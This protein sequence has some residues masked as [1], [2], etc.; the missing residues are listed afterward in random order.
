[1]QLN[2]KGEII[3]TKDC[4]TSVPGLF[5]AGDLTDITYKQIVISAGEGVK[6]ALQAYKFIQQGAGSVG[7]DWGKK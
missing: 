5:A 1:V 7:A 6:A 2:E 3:T 4:Q